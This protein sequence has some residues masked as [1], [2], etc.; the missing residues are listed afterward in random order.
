M[1]ISQILAII[2]ALISLSLPACQTHEDQHDSGRHN[3][4][5]TSP[6]VT[7]VILTQQ[8]VCQIHAR[9][10][11][12]V[13]ALQDGYLEG[14]TVK[15]GQQVKVG[16][17]LFSVV[18]ILYEAKYDAE[19]AEAD[20]AELELKYTATLAEKKAVS[21]REV[22]LYKAKL[23]R[24]N[25][26]AILAKRELDFCKVKAPF[27][28]I[29][30]RLLEMQGSL[31]KERDILTTLSDNSVMWVYFN[32]PEARYLEYIRSSAQEKEDQRIELVLADGSKFTY[33][34]AMGRLVTTGNFQPFNQ[35]HPSGAIEAKFNNET[36]TVPFRADF[37]NPHR[38]LRHGMT[39]TILVHRPLQYAI[40][41]P[42]RA[43]F[44]IL[45]KRY[46]Y[47]VDSEGVVH[48]REIKVQ[49]ELDDIYVISRGISAHDKFIYE[50]IRQVR[51][52]ATV[53]YEFRPPEQILGRQ[54][55]HAE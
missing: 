41:I 20:L 54:R 9:R 33:P 45:E 18:P 13:R 47:V 3:I 1:R 36:G 19:Q 49:H 35:S 22:A 5:V 26:K 28:G 48:Q 15:E 11:I 44:E 2:V 40:V 12:N 51:D 34:D 50:G 10:H 23:A 21:E 38:L 7:N 55:L 52:G 39:G 32:V 27:D 14:I 31:I 30:D 6:K 8:Y 53:E 17:V 16:D 29:I 43:T 24:A 4:V 37:P 42:Q 25:A 46:V